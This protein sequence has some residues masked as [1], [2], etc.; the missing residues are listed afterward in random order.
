MSGKKHYQ[1]IQIKDDNERLYKEISDEERQKQLDTLLDFMN[2]FITDNDYD[3][4]C[5]CGNESIIYQIINKVHQ[6]KQYFKI[7]HKIII[8]DLKELALNCFWIV[9]LKPICIDKDLSENQ[10]VELR[11]INEKFAIYYIIKVMRT[12]INQYFDIDEERKEA[13]KKLNAFFDKL[14]IYELTYC[15][16]YRDVSKEAFIML[17]ET[18]AKGVGIQPYNTATISHSDN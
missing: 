12:L 9:K 7:F 16:F 6:R 15:L 10:K 18:I 4:N 5:I 1:S 17:V 14:Y 8:S 11:Y 13:Q 2:D 3:V